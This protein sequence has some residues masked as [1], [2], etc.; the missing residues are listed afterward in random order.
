M[1]R[2]LLT[3]GANISYQVLYLGLGGARHRQDD[4][5]PILQMLGDPHWGKGNT[6]EI[7]QRT[8]EF[9][10]A[11]GVELLFVDEIQ[12]LAR[13]STDRTDVTDELKRLLDLGIVPVVLAGNEE[14]SAFSEFSPV[15]GARPRSSPR[16]NRSARTWRR[17]G[18]WTGCQRPTRSLTVATSGQ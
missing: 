10:H 2:T 5:L 12:H 3:T 11:R 8:R 1:S 7:K 15:N 14:S 4:V 13:E 16:S 17:Q 9:M 6:D 18:F